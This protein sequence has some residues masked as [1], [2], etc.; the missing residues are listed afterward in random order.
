MS[1]RRAPDVTEERGETTG[2]RG[3]VLPCS[4][5]ILLAPRREDSWLGGNYF[6]YGLAF[7]VYGQSISMEMEMTTIQSRLGGYGFGY[8]NMV[9]PGQSISM[10]MTNNK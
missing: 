2:G 8:N 7:M 1:R 3:G 9:N 4:S 5:C 10:S 6:W